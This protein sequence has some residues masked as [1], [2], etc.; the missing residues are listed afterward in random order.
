MAEGLLYSLV[1]LVFNLIAYLSVLRV[2]SAEVEPGFIQ[3]I[4]TIFELS[5]FKNESLKT[6]VNFE[7]LKGT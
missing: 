1:V 2:W 3:A 5:S 4:I 6:M 7:A